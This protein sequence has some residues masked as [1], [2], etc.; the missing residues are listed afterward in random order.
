MTFV[1]AAGVGDVDDAADDSI[2][3]SVFCTE[4]AVGEAGTGE[5]A[6]LLL[7]ASTFSEEFER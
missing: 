5:L 1:D 7:S 6:C 4:R 2:R 3:F